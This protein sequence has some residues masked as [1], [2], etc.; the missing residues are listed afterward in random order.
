MRPRLIVIDDDKHCRELLSL[1]LTQ[2]GY[3]VISLEEPVA[4]PLY[5]DLESQC[6]HDDACGDFLL[7]DNRMPRMSGL[8][9]IE[10]QQRRG[11]KGAVGNKAVISAS[12]TEDELEHAHRMG[13]QIF[14]KPYDVEHVLKWL[15]EKERLLP[16]GRKLVAIGE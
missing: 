4:C 7:T 8:Q 3:E 11:C 15:G 13:C 5:S 6:P 9:F 2:K 10:I 1:I 12:W 16:V 14:R